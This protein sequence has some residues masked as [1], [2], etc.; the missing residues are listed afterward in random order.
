[1]ER[2][3]N[4]T[5]ASSQFKIRITPRTQP[6]QAGQTREQVAQEA[7][8]AMAKEATPESIAAETIAINRAEAART[9]NLPPMERQRIRNEVMNAAA[10]SMAAE[11]TPQAAEEEKKNNRS[12]K[13]RGGYKTHHIQTIEQSNGFSR[14]E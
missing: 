10:R 13:S 12:S 14:T 8:R 5:E 7:Y 1:M 3:S 9:R 4:V 6:S 11:A 2:S